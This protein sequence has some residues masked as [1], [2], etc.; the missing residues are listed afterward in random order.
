NFLKVIVDPANPNVDIVAVHGLN[1][2][3]A[4]CHAEATWTAGDKL[5]LRDFLPQQ[6]PNAR[7][8]LFGYNS[9]VAFNTSTAG[10]EEQAGSLL[11][12]LSFKRV[13]TEDRPTI[14]VA[15]SLGGIIV[16]K[17]LVAAKLD[18]T[19]KAIREATF[20]IAFFGTPHQGGELAKLGDIAAS[21]MRAVFR[22]P[23]NTFL[24]ALKKNSIF[25][26]GVI[27]DFRH[28]LED[29]YIVS[30]YET[31]RMAI[32]GLIVDKKSATLGL[33]GTRERQIPVDADHKDLCKFAGAE[34][35]DYEAVS[36]N[37]VWLANCAIKA[38]AER[39]RKVLVKVSSSDS[40]TE[41]RVKMLRKIFKWL[42][43]P[44]TT[45][46]F[47]AAIMKRTAKTGSWL[48]QSSQVD[49][50]MTTKP[51]LLWLYGKPG[52]GKT[53]LSTTVIENIRN[54]CEARKN[55]ASA[56][57]Y[58]TFT[59]MEKRKH[60]NMIRSVITQLC[61]QC[62][63]IPTAVR[64]LFDKCED[65]MRQPTEVELMKVL[66]CLIDEF[67]E[68]YI[69][70]DALDECD[71][72]QELCI[73]LQEIVGW[74]SERLHVFIT[75]RPEE[76]IR[77]TLEYLRLDQ[78]QMVNMASES[79]NDDIREYVEQRI[80]NDVGLKRWK[81]R[82]LVQKRIAE[83]LMD[84]ADGMFR[85]AE[86]QL[87]ALRVCLNLSSLEA[88]LASLPRTLDE[89]Y[90][91]ILRNIEPELQDYALKILQWLVYSERPL[92]ME[93]VV[94]V[95][96]T[97]RK[98]KP[99]FDPDDR[100]PDPRDILLI[101]PSLI[102]V[103]TATH[104]IP[105]IGKYEAQEL[106]LAH[107]SIKEY[108]VSDRICEEANFYRIRKIPAQSVIAETCLAYLLSL[109][110]RD[111]LSSLGAEFLKEFPLVQYAGAF[112]MLHASRVDLIVGPTAEMSTEL[113]TGNSNAFIHWAHWCP[114]LRQQK[115]DLTKWTKKISTPLCY[116]VYYDLFPQVLRLLEEGADVNAHAWAFGNA[117]Q[118]ASVSG[119]KFIVQFLLKKGA[120][121][122][123]QGGFF[124][125]ALQAA[126]S[127]GYKAIV[128]LLL[129]KG[130][131]INAQG[132]YF[133]TALHVA[134]FYGYKAIVQLLLEKG[135]DVNARVE[136]LGTALRGALFRGHKAIMQ[137]LL[138][139]GADIST[140]GKP[141]GNLSQAAFGEGHE[142]IV[143]LLLKIHADRTAKNH[144]QIMRLELKSYL[145]DDP[146]GFERGVRRLL[147]DEDDSEE[148]KKFK[149]VMRLLLEDDFEDDS[150][151]TRLFHDYSERQGRDNN[152]E[153]TDDEAC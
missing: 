44:D 37:L 57:F 67:N 36:A 31:R 84:R 135:A 118:A 134:S 133:G 78:D 86:C 142:A 50:W 124:G 59:D 85:W 100:F 21:I 101:C 103:E 119:N 141:Y 13:D 108:L 5:W 143:Q 80:R 48:L 15:Y 115:T 139:K 92:R 91:R 77:N 150:E 71:R 10:V 28:Q 45:S 113:F 56:Y 114:I 137:L 111:P 87:D 75:S 38:A 140:L 1:T 29:Y 61:S 70:L 89:T 68:T 152:I 14:F 32:H 109:G 98:P 130:A 131:D 17:A 90:A 12:K 149:R 26:N 35:S 95:L 105:R 22:N 49:K 25:S 8:L 7:I 58:F 76:D 20:G 82:P 93:E 18:D 120:D 104:F 41:F 42:S 81:Q 55:Q 54:H 128:Q 47:D 88:A 153:E 24:E 96:A 66:Q 43:P 116:A 72:R 136:K 145:E 127:H 2:T 110:D 3:N 74:R 73:C 132:G 60:Q 51:S 94:D 30:F 6:L 52:C 122:N 121:I 125:N 65:G 4:E 34:G 126:S 117:L 16:K 62:L 144:K 69:V 64:N 63:D 97:K 83:I 33:S 40:T 23:K 46:D 148:L 151:V 147:E 112:G 106:R 138:E 9:N 102:T 27:D 19:Y 129:E 99:R 53:I 123:A 107:F 39:S 79:I 11:N 146:G